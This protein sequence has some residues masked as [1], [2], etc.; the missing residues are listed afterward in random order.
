MGLGTLMLEEIISWAKEMG[1]L[2]RLELDVQVRNERA[3]HLYRKMGF[4]IEAVMPRGAR[5]DLGEF[6][7]VYKMSYLIE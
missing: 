3:V 2:F 7:D 4:Q 1:V 6:L 5:T